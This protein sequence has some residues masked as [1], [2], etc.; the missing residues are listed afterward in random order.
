MSPHPEVTAFLAQLDAVGRRP[1]TELEP[2]EFRANLRAM[3]VLASRPEHPV[4]TED[5]VVPGP[6]GDISVRLYRP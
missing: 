1:I 2:A 4:P 5:T 6:A 3:S